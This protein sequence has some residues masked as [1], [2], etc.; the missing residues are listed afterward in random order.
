MTAGRG[1]LA[2]AAIIVGRWMPLGTVAACLVF[3]AAEALDLRVQIL[4]LPISSYY[5]QMLPYIIAL[6][7]LVGLGR[8]AQLPAAIGAFFDRDAQ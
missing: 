2:L 3:G 1:Y 8:S 7:V 6:A 5:V 4:G